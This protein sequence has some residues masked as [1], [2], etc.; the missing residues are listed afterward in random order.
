MFENKD[1]CQKLDH[2]D[3]QSHVILL[4]EFWAPKQIVVKYMEMKQTGGIHIVTTKTI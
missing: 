1:R 2:C 4:D 3:C